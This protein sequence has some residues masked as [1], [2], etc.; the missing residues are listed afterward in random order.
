MAGPALEVP[1]PVVLDDSPL[2]VRHVLVPGE[3]VL[4]PGV[5]TADDGR[6]LGSFLRCLH[7]LPVSIY[8]ET[9]VPDQAAARAELLATLERLLHRITPLL[10]EHLRAP[11]RGL[12]R[13]VALGTPGTLVH[14]N[15]VGHHLLHRDGGI[16]GVIDWS[17]ARVA[18]P[19]LDL[20]WALYAT[21]EPFAAAVAS[22]Y[23]VT[24]DELARALDW[25]R[26]APWYDAL[27]GLGPGG[28]SFVDDG[29]AEVAARL[30]VTEMA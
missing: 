16:G 3:P 8:V 7:D 1:V 17:D 27:W 24:D 23:G 12:L 4:D 25:Y 18:D 20:G 6:R 26:L 10:P 11:G 15:L 29:L 19:A 22:A 28:R 21:P 5:L 2:R 14:G 13:R 30:D 9:G